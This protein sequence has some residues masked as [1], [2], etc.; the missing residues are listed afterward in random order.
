MAGIDKTYTNSYKEYKEFKDWADKQS[1]TFYTGR[2]AC[3]G[4][5]VYNIKEEDFNGTMVIMNSPTWLDIYLAQH[6]PFQFVIGNLKSVYGATFDSLNKID[7]SAKPSEDFQ[8]NRK[9][10]IRKSKRSKFPIHSKPYGGFDW[11]VTCDD[12]L[13][14]LWYDLST[15][16][17]VDCKVHPYSSNWSHVGSIK[18]VI[19]HLRK[20]YLPKGI[21]FRITGMYHGEEYIAKIY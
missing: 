14:G 19:R 4:N 17:W 12:Y 3:I 16:Q 11:G 2:T 5:W 7:L 6:C 9:I 15:D 10:R 20:S 18:A 8:Q 13:W 1:V 21:K